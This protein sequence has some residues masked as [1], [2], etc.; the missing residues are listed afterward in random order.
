V[1]FYR[2]PGGV[3]ISRIRLNPGETKA[4]RIPR[5]GVY[6]YFC[7][8]HGNVNSGTCTGMCGRIRGH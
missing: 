2:T 5:A 1:I 8:L 3:N 7:N 6:K 4:R